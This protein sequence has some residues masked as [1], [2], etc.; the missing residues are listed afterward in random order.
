ED[1]DV[2]EVVELVRQRAREFADIGQPVQFIQRGAG[3]H[4]VEIRG[5]LVPSQ[6]R[7]D[8]RARLQEWVGVRETGTFSPSY[9]GTTPRGEKTLPG[10][11]AG[12]RAVGNRVPIF[13]PRSSDGEEAPLTPT[14]SASAGA[15][16]ARA[17]DA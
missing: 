7:A 11:A 5:H 4:G 15:R 2:E 17:V 3:G 14:R 9:R 16:G 1:E 13:A 10:A 6:A 12:P 8:G